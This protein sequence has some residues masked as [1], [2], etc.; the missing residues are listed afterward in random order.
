MALRRLAVALIAL[1]I[2]GCSSAHA[3]PTVT[4]GAQPDAESVLTAHLYAAALRYY[5]TATRVQ[6]A[7]DPLTE[8]DSGEV[9]V[10]PGFTG[11]LLERFQ[12]G[13]TARADEQVYRDLLSSLP[14]G[15]AAGDYTISAQDKPALAVTE[16][17][18]EAWGGQ[19][20]SAM[21]RN[22]ADVRPG[23]VDGAQNPSVIGGC[24]LP[25][26]SE[27]ADEASLFDALQAGQ[28][29]AAWTT[30]ADPGIPSE[31]VVLADG[32]AL[33]RAQ[34]LVPLYR[35]NELNEAQVLALNEVAGVLDTAGLAQMR[36]QVADGA[37]PA[38]LAD[39]WLSENP[40]RA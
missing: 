1:V 30:T 21:I 6:P 35:R 3:P 37:D 2:V 20:L 14:E 25:Q 11:Q 19:D 36:A 24:R 7:P 32:T 23:A 33:I 4:L 13:A 29:N 15:I 40:L 26:A 10:V 16:E 31:L 34:N 39:A 9:T 17:T 12:T 38:Q 22:C 5:G 8:L 18:A 28:V 27:F